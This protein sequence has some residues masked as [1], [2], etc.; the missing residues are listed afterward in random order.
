MGCCKSKSKVNSGKQNENQ[1]TDDIGN[2]KQ[3][4][5]GDEGQVKECLSLEDLDHHISADTKEMIV[6][7]FAT[8]WCNRCKKVSPVIQKLAS[9]HES[10]KFLKV[11]ADIEGL[12]EKY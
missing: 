10:I 5:V 7:E 12:G 3:Q 6:V 8:E 4:P 2:E 1:K 11:D 9:E